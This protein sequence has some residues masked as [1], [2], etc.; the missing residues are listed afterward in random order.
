MTMF[1]AVLLDETRCEFGAS[2][3]ARSK[4][5]AWEKLRNRYPECAVVQV[6]SPA[7]RR[8]RERALQRAIHEELNYEMG[9]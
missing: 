5:A 8:R 9:W 7:D 4:E 3:A 6:E 2:V 1:H